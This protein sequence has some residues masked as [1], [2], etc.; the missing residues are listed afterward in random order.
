MKRKKLYSMRALGLAMSLVMSV[1]VSAAGA[2]SP[3]TDTTVVETP[4]EDGTTTVVET[5][6]KEDGSVSKT[7][8]VKDENGNVIRDTTTSTNAAGQITEVVVNNTL[9]ATDEI[10]DLAGSAEAMPSGNT[11]ADA[12]VLPPED[13]ADE[14]QKAELESESM[15]QF[16]AIKVD[17]IKVDK[18]GLNIKVSPVAAAVQSV[19]KQAAAKMAATMGLSVADDKISLMASAEISV[20][21]QDGTVNVKI[22]M[23][24]T[25]DTSRYTYY[26]L[27]FDVV[28]GKWETVKAQITN[29]GIVLAAFDS[30]SPVFVVRADAKLPAVDN[31]D[32]NN[33]GD[34][35]NNGGNGDNGSGDNGSSDSSNSGTGSNA[36]GNSSKAGTAP[37]SITPANPGVSPKTGE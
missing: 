25:P 34:N 37:A 24:E 13:V 35:G 5:T 16:T 33:N 29:D 7:E 20:E 30:L 3:D 17:E 9:S 8:T 10:T 36:S 12:D 6:T 18:A 14:T 23:T 2:L 27:H 28:N 22:P 4:N 19:A 26:V 31:G 32:N 15:N 11:V 1:P 21:N